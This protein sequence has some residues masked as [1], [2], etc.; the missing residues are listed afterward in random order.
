MASN[1]LFHSINLALLMAVMQDA[2]A[3]SALHNWDVA[4]PRRAT[5]TMEREKASASST[6]I[7]IPQGV[8]AYSCSYLLLITS[9]Q[10]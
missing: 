8:Y 10:P 2:F 9:L 3:S 5:K 7:L 4:R 1:M 6:G